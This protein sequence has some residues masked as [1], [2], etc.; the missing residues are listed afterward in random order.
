MS[1]LYSYRNLNL[2]PI[3]CNFHEGKKNSIKVESSLFAIY[4][5]SGYRKFY[6]RS[7][8]LK[9]RPLSQKHIL[10]FRFTTHS[11]PTLNFRIFRLI[12]YNIFR[13]IHLFFFI[14]FILFFIFLDTATTHSIKYYN[15]KKFQSKH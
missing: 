2:T 1:N 15:N 9:I 11:R 12:C 7:F 4:S 8:Y 10:I 6:N 14:F 5:I 3:F 13:R